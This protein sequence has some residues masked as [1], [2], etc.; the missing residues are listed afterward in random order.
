MSIVAAKR[1]PLG[2]AYLAR[3][4]RWLPGRGDATVDLLWVALALALVRGIIYALLNPP[5][6]SPDERDHVQYVRY[7]ATGQGERGAEGH[8]PV[9]YYLLM[10]PAYLLAAA[11]GR[12]MEDLAIRL[13]SVP[14]LMG[15]VLFT[16]LAA[17]R[18]APGRPVVPVVATALVGLHPQLAYIGASANNDNAAN[19]MAAVLTYLMVTLLSKDVPAWAV[20]TTAVALGAALMTKGQI[21]PVMGLYGLV[22]FLKVLSWA[23]PRHR[24]ATLAALA[25]AAAVVQVALSTPEGAIMRARLMGNLGL[26]LVGLHDL[27]AA[28]GRFGTEALWYEYS[29][30]WAAFM[31]ES[32]RLP[33]ELYLL[34]TLLVAAGLVGAAVR[35]VVPAAG[36]RGA[37]RA[38]LLVLILAVVVQ[39]S[40]QYLLH[41]TLVNS[42]PTEAYLLQTI[43]G[44]YLFVALPALALLAAEGLDA[45]AGGRAG[46]PRPWVA[47]VAVAVLALFEAASLGA[48]GW[49]YRAWASVG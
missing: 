16:W 19:L 2:I 49:G 27:G 23:L 6:G 8:Q 14:F 18:M 10:V 24:A 48:L 41:L 35:V 32:L 39:A 28:A 13:A 11:G 36:G 26:L 21:L 37:G 34:A 9:P 42:Y 3:T 46:S 31:G 1:H 45:L 17:R 7:L 38:M 43:Q 44:R 25:L 22:L 33:A 4:D 30:F 12:E 40:A 15:M 47:A 5:F 20:P 29:S